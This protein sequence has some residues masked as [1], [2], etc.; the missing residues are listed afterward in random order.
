MNRPGSGIEEIVANRASARART[1]RAAI[2]CAVAAAFAGSALLGLSG[3]FLVG[4]GLA[5]L[6]GAAEA[7][8]VSG[9]RPR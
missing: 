8:T 1:M 2:L 6:A 4:A 5:G 7:W 3:W 9:M